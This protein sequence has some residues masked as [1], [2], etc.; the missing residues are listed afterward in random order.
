MVEFSQLNRGSAYFD[1]QPK[2]GP[3]SRIWALVNSNRDL[4]GPSS[5]FRDGPFFVVEA[6]ASFEHP[7]RRDWTDYVP[8]KSFYM[9]PWT[10]AEVIQV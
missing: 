3:D 8:H 4:D 2:D 1:L 5:V 7:A 9:K 6:E 10:F